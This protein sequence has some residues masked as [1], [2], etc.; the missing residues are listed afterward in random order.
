MSKRVSAL[1]T[2][3][4]FAFLEGFESSSI[5]K[6]SVLRCLLRLFGN[7]EVDVWGVRTE[8]ELLHRCLN[9]LRIAT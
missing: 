5:S 1:L 8:D 3:E 6:A 4:Q 9:S 2:N 7:V